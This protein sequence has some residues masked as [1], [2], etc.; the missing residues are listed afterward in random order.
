MYTVE[1]YDAPA[2]A[3]LVIDLAALGMLPLLLQLFGV[4]EVSGLRVQLWQT[5]KVKLVNLDGH[6]A[7]GDRRL[8]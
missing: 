3:Q 1:G 6:S 7:T 8:V 4:G 2:D 5:L